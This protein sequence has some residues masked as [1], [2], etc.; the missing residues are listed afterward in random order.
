M[1]NTNAI[2]SIDLSNAYNGVAGY[3]V[4][5]VGL[6]TFVNNWAGPIWWSVGSS[7]LLIPPSAVP[8]AKSRRAWIKQEHEALKASSSGV[9]NGEEPDAVKRLKTSVAAAT[10][11]A[12][13]VQA[14]QFPSERSA[15]IPSGGS[16][17]LQQKA[18]NNPSV[19][20]LSTWLTVQTLFTSSALL[21]VMLAC[22]ALRTHLFIWT[23]FSPKYL[24]AMAW[25]IA[26]H[27]G[28]S[29]GLTTGISLLAV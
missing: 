4:G 26:Q 29:V 24:Y 15:G 10:P 28:I 11:G 8:T 1:G 27:L 22:T 3:N 12:K 21:A 25:T 20:P 16:S 7:L 2:S 18:G 17:Q 23:V 14:D 13:P 5:A 19:G 6:L 9:H